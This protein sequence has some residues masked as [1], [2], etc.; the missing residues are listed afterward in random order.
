MSVTITLPPQV[1]RCINTLKTTGHSAYVVGGCV[2]DS[3][4]GITPHDWDLTTDALPEEIKE[5]FHAYKTIDTGIRHGTVSVLID[6]M[7]LE[8]TTF[9]TDGEYTDHRRPDNV[10]FTSNLEDDLARR[11]F[12]IG[13]MAYHPQ[14]GLIDPFCGQ[15][16]LK[17]RRIRC[18]G[19]PI[20]RFSEDAL[21]ILRAFRFSA[22][23]GFDF[24]AAT[25]NGAKDCRHLLGKIAVE[26]ISS[27]LSRLLLSGNPAKAL[28]AMHHSNVLEAV[29]PALAAAL[30]ADRYFTVLDHSPADIYIRMA[31]LLRCLP[32]E[33]GGSLLRELKF[34]GQTIHKVKKILTE[35]AHPPALTARDMRFLLHRCGPKTA[36]SVIEVLIADRR[37]DRLARDMLQNTIS[38]HPC[39]QIKDLAVSGTDLK[40]IGIPANDK[41]GVVLKYLLNAVLEYPS[42]NNRDQLLDMAVQKYNSLVQ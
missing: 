22:Q 24:D 36:A 37:I 13:A 20:K 39:Y 40:K 32:P 16:D 29:A 33:K 15:E 6:H 35:I 26:R 18:V 14:K 30:P 19:D 17:K 3:L 27:E 1:L 11:D 8:I 28:E 2:R 12:T 42:C 38:F 23:L 41:M 7:Q 34:D 5:C 25:L 10:F 9:R 31:L 21:R 4:R